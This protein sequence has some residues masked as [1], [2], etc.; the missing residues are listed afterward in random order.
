MASWSDAYQN[1]SGATDPN[2]L[3]GMQFDEPSLWDTYGSKSSGRYDP[4]SI[5]AFKKQKINELQAQQAL[6][7]QQRL[8]EFATTGKP[9]SE[10]GFSNLNAPQN[11]NESGGLPSNF[12]TQPFTPQEMMN[13]LVKKSLAEFKTN[14]A[15]TTALSNALNGPTAENI[16]ALHPILGKEA[17]QYLKEG[18]LMMG[19]KAN[20]E[21]SDF[22][23]QLADAFTHSSDLND[24]VGRYG[25]LVK[26]TGVDPEKARV[27]L[28]D[29]AKQFTDKEEGAYKVGHLR[30][31]E[32]G[33]TKIYESFLGGDPND[34]KNW[35]PASTAEKDKPQ[36][37]GFSAYMRRPVS[38]FDSKLGRVVKVAAGSAVEEPERYIDPRDPDVVTLTQA[39]RYEGA[40]GGF[41]K[42]IDGMGK[43][44]TNIMNK[45]GLNKNPKIANYTIQQLVQNKLLGSGDVAGLNNAMMG[46]RCSCRSCRHR[47]H[48]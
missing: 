48:P 29:F 24:F 41:V 35:K 38:M 30:E 8:A 44:V 28:E 14:Q 47:S 9:L 43:L 33:R 3:Q 20:P 11:V 4:L 26:S 34:L 18:R 31:R 22:T 6:P 19:K 17:P 45:T 16:A 2:A 1:I 40:V 32:S 7:A 25:T 13:P 5:E 39:S 37:D 10:M 27:Q 36:Q 12:T 42:S 46:L 21:L 23:V 15:G